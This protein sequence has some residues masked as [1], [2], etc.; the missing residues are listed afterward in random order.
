MVPR[1]LFLE[2]FGSYLMT[3]RPARCHRDLSNAFSS[4]NRL[5][6]EINAGLADPST[7]RS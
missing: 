5:K 4:I 1:A 2:E 3:G 7:S 6:E